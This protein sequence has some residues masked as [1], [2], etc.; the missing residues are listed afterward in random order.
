MPLASRN[1]PTI[2]VILGVTGDLAARKILPALF[3][4]FVKGELPTRFRIVGFARR[5]FAPDAFRALISEIVT[6]HAQRAGTAGRIEPFLELIQYERGFF[7]DE[8]YYHA[9]STTLTGIDAQWGLCSNKLFYLSVPPHMYEQILRHLASS[10]LTKSCSDEEGW[11]RVLVEKPFGKDA[12]TAETLDTLLGTLFREE[13]IYRIDHYLAKEMIQNILVFRFSNSLFEEIW[14]GENIEH[15]RIT[16][17]EKLGVERRGAFY[18]GLGALRDVG[19]NHLLAMLAL[20]TMEHP[21][22]FAGDAVR[23][24]RAEVLTA[25]P[26]TP[27]PRIAT[28]TFRAQY[29]GYR[30][31][32]D[33]AP[34]SETE[35]FFRIK[36]VLT[37]PRWNG[38]PVIMESGKRM[39]AQRK[40]VVVTFKH[41]VPC[42]CPPDHDHYKNK[43]I[44][45]L[46]PTEGIKIQFWSKRPGLT[47][48]LEERDFD[49]LLRDSRERAQYVEEYEKLLLD[50]IVGDQML[51]LSTAEVKEMWRFIDP[52]IAAWQ[53]NAVPL[54]TYEPDREKVLELAKH[55]SF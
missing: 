46:E 12:R 36:T 18:D 30:E 28:D 24:R 15:I 49:F 25:L 19:Q 38:V 39:H 22:S 45:S 33:I 26:E 10:G 40:E 11:T 13:Q 37:S 7:E 52:I 47:F 17:F 20:V 6:P 4:L 54:A 34:H 1:A 44:F 29:A 23:K 50:C 27:P 43:I 42:L 16:L 48:A 5:E 9:L 3:H 55:I 53:A 41:P 32:Q 8:Q 14:N 31:I 51:F 21:Q 2:L 35:T